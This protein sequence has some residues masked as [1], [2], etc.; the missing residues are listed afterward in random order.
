MFEGLKKFVNKVGKKMQDMTA[1]T[2]LAS[3]TKSWL[4][5]TLTAWIDSKERKA[6]LD[7]ERYY[8]GDQDI[9]YRERKAI[10]ASGRLEPVKNVANNRILNNVYRYMVD[11]KRNFSF[12][13]PFIFYGKN[14]AMTDV[15][16]K[17]FDDNFMRT[18]NILAEKAQN[19]G[20]AALYPYYDEDGDFCFEIFKGSELLPIWKDSLHTKLHFCIRYYTVEKQK[21]FGSETVEKVQIF[22]KEA[23][24][25]Y[26]RSSGKLIPDTDSGEVTH[27]MTVNRVVDPVTNQI[28]RVAYGWDRVP[29]VFFR[30]N[31]EEQPLL[32]RCRSLQDA[33]NEVWS[34][35]KNQMDE[36]PGS[37]ILVLHNY[38]GE[39][40]KE[41]RSR[42]AVHRTI[43]VRSVDGIDGRVETLKVEVNADN[44]ELILRLLKKSII[45]QCRGFDV[46]DDNVG[47]NAN[48][49][50]IS[51]MY[52]DCELDA[53]EF[54]LEF[55]SSLQQLLFFV[56]AHLANTGKGNYTEDDITFTFDRD[57]IQDWNSDMQTL[58]QMANVYPKR[59]IYEQTPGVGNPQRL[60][61]M[62][63]EA[64]RKAME[65]YSLPI[66]QHDEHDNGID[67]DKDD[68]KTAK[69]DN[70]NL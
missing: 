46:K 66:P 18:I 37:S 40:L 28:E 15:F 57:M 36:D 67:D 39:D 32:C 56:R 70:S 43:K 8:I 9:N 14:D 55:R 61:D 60:I 17:V 44:Y 5:D 34:N 33:Y 11:Q 59:F 27:Y 38:D 42:L 23:V 54:E 52:N 4:E 49:M 13:K 51:A 22:T 3:E 1:E 53:N 26:V 25:N 64:E 19:G 24:Y 41:F 31:S 12:G 62:D 21:T 35:F 16:R 2:I 50:H 69:K 47:G 6:Q 63:E 29:I 45:E 65:S 20:K 10:G 48:Q 58:V 30:F 7:A 68:E